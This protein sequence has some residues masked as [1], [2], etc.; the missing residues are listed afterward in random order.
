MSEQENKTATE[1]ENQAADPASK[2]PEVVET[3]ETENVSEAASGDDQSKLLERLDQVTAEANDYRDRYL[4]SVADLDNLRKRSVRDRD[5]TR[6]AATCRV[7]EEFLPVMD[8]FK[9]GLQAARQHEG[10]SA[11]ADGFAMVLTQMEGVLTQLGVD[12]LNPAGEPFDANH[13]ESIAHIPHESVPDGHVIEVSRVG[14]RY[15]DRLLRA[16]AVVV[17]S[18]PPAKS[19]SSEKSE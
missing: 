14:Y 4:R 8:N 13:H 17:S 12:T 11:F 10:G 2:N 18:G 5:D 1:P 15:H 7:I 19:E 16:A 3:P 9:L 6:K